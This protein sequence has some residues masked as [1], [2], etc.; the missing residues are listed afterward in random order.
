MQRYIFAGVVLAVSATQVPLLTEKL[1]TR[2]Q[3]EPRNRSNQQVAAVAKQES[4]KKL[5]K[6]TSLSGRSARIEMDNRGHFVTEARLNGKRVEVLVD[7]G[8]T[9]VAINE[10]T[11]KRLGIRLKNE[12]FRYPVNTANGT[13][14]VAAATIDEIRIGR[15]RVKNV[16]ATVARDKSLNSTLLGMT[17]LK[18]LKKFE[19]K[20]RELI[21]KQ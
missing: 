17:F 4:E 11:A 12:D 15:V 9:A 18:E 6:V 16:R 20:N 10:S 1:E 21:L 19:I 3:N 2:V 8:A 7:T 13:I 14:H 5:P